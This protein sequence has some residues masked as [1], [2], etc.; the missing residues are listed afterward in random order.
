MT[1]IPLIVQKPTVTV[2]RHQRTTDGGIVAM[3]GGITHGV[4][5]EMDVIVIMGGNP[6]LLGMLGLTAL[7]MVLV[8]MGGKTRNYSTDALTSRSDRSVNSVASRSKSVGKNPKDMIGITSKINKLNLRS[9]SGT[10]DAQSNK[11]RD[12][13]INRTLS[14]R[15]VLKN[16]SVHKEKIKRSS[17][18][19]AMKETK[20]KSARK[21]KHSVSDTKI[22][23]TKI[24]SKEQDK[25][26]SASEKQENGVQGKQENGSVKLSAGE[27]TVQ[28][29]HTQGMHESKKSKPPLPKPK[30]NRA[31]KS[32]LNPLNTRPYGYS[33]KRLTARPS[34]PANLVDGGKVHYVNQIVNDRPKSAGLP[35]IAYRHRLQPSYDARIFAVRV[36]D[37]S[38]EESSLTLESSSDEC[39]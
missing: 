30:A 39:G 6:D 33:Q 11:H 34:V 16:G 28:N 1:R 3:R 18:V 23:A 26:S 21:M 10:P 4:P 22:A 37:S 35:K 25:K 15:N 5:R 24:T 17:S 12:K 36:P 32:P 38:S 27:G 13:V 9:K 29:G 14:E 8:T 19:G 7:R 2:I 20:D 31:A